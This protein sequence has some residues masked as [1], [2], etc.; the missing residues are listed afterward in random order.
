MGKRTSN[1]FRGNKWFW[2]ACIVFIA[3]QYV[4]CIHY[5]MKREFLFCDEVYSYGLANSNDYTFLHP[6]E[7]NEPLDNWVSGNYFTDYMNYNDDSFNYHAAYV[8]QERDVHPPLYY[9]LLHTVCSFFKNAGYS[10]VPGI[11]LNLI[12]LIFVD[13]LLLYVAVNLLGDRWKGLIATALWGISAVGI[14]NCMLIR[15]YLLQTMEVLILV[16]AHIFILKHRRR[17]TIP[18]FIM[19]AFTVFLGGITHYYFY[20]FV[21]GLGLCVCIYL[22]STKRIKEMFDYGFSLVAGLALAMAVFPATRDHIFGYRG[23]YATKNLAGFAT[24]KFLA[25]I[26]YI[27]RAYFA[28]I[29]PIFLIIIVAL[30]IIYIISKFVIIHVSLSR[31]QNAISYKVDVNR[32]IITGEYTGTLS[33]ESLLFAAVVIA[34]AIFA[35]VGIQ[36][37]ELVNA[38]YIYSALPILAIFIVWMMTKLVSVVSPGHYMA[39]IAVVCLV[40][41]AGSIKVNGIDWQ[42]NTYS[43]QKAAVEEMKGKDCLI[44]C[45]GDGSWNNIYAGVNA[46]SVMGRCRYV[47]V[48]N[49]KSVPELTK[50]CGDDM[51]IAVIND[52]KFNKNGINKKFKYIKKNTKYKSIERIYSYSGVQIYR[53][54]VSGDQEEVR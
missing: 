33:A 19:L 43:E 13:I 20:F 23:N 29:L 31:K 35:F 50:D 47:Y 22:L 11:V 25:Y 28:G 38:R 6:G 39:V 1:V 37:S 12:I 40:L 51:Y 49:I 5:G 8:N 10:A 53:M 34:D 52:P 18:Y 3:L 27:N 14:S 15:M 7:N 26:K 30:I 48:D 2:I 4:L 46:F 32:R 9:M 24:R 45:H 16:A 36:G 17:M 42:Y 54:T 41:C 44:I 21:A